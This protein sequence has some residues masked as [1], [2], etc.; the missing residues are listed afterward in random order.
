MFCR[1]VF[2]LTAFDFLGQDSTEYPRFVMNQ[3][4]VDTWKLF[5]L[6]T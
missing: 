1:E 3:Q 2:S 6:E 5:D 4:M